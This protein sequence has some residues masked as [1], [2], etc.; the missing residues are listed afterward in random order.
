[1]QEI[2]SIIN[3]FCGT[4]DGFPDTD[5]PLADMQAKGIDRGKYDAT[6]SI[7]RN[8]RKVVDFLR[9]FGDEALT[10]VFENM[11]EPSCKAVLMDAQS[12]YKIAK[13]LPIRCQLQKTNT[14]PPN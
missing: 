4:V 3:D 2:T 9:I 10:P 12:L 5:A 14:V 6:L 7:R 1:M 8:L 11:P 13:D